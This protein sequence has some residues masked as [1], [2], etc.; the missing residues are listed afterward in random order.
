MTNFFLIEEENVR[1]DNL[2]AKILP[3]FSRSHIKTMIDEGKI[4][5]NGKVVKAGAKG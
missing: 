2:V 3:Q 1:L 5:L 4:T